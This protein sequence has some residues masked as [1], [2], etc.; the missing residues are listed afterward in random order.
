VEPSYAFVSEL[1][2]VPTGGWAGHNALERFDGDRSPI[3]FR[4]SSKL[5]P[6]RKMLNA[7]DIDIGSEQLQKTILSFITIRR[8]LKKQCWLND[9]NTR[10]SE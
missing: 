5:I 6:A 3:K 4:I 10:S 1:A 8:M 7:G 9:W 2:R